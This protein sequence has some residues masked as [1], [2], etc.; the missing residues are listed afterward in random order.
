MPNYGE[1]EG[2]L[3]KDREVGE[4]WHQIDQCY[5]T[6]IRAP[7]RYSYQSEVQ[8]SKQNDNQVVWRPSIEIT[9]GQQVYRAGKIVFP[10]WQRMHVNVCKCKKFM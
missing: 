3:M 2:R 4:P 8:V 1:E 6:G 7:S 9:K 10:E 5:Q